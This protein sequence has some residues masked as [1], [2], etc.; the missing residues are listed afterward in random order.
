MEEIIP[1]NKHQP[2]KANPDEILNKVNSSSQYVGQMDEKDAKDNAGIDENGS[3]NDVW[4]N[5]VTTAKRAHVDTQ[6]REDKQ[7][8]T[9]RINGNLLV[10]KNKYFDGLTKLS[11]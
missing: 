11:P 6:I 1:E 5:F 2:V 4:R 8:F 7:V 10:I 9:D 3:T